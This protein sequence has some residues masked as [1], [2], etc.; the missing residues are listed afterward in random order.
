M[1]RVSTHGWRSAG[2]QGLIPAAGQGSVQTAPRR[3]A[4]R[5][6]HGTPRESRGEQPSPR[7]W[8]PSSEPSAQSWTPFQRRDMRTHS[9]VPRQLCSFG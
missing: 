2:A 5:P 7:Q 4:S 3:Q 1:T 9:S 6:T 8:G